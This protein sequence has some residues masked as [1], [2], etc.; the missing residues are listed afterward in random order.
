MEQTETPADD[1][2]L[3][4]S[5]PEFIREP[6]PWFDRIL[7]DHPIVKLSDGSYVISKHADVMKYAKHPTLCRCH[8]TASATAPGQ[9]TSTRDC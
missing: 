5:D 7:R 8:P 9:L 2:L 6:W 4:W 1:E 3:P